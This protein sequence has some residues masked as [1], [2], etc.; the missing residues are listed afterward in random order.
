MGIYKE[1]LTKI[2]ANW[3]K[4]F[5]EQYKI[6][7]NTVERENQTAHASPTVEFGSYFCH[8]ISEISAFQIAAKCCKM[9]M[10]TSYWHLS[11]RLRSQLHSTVNS[12]NIGCFFPQIF[13]SLKHLKALTYKKSKQYCL[14]RLFFPSCGNHNDELFYRY[15]I[16]LFVSPIIESQCIWFVVQYIA[17]PFLAYLQFTTNCE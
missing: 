6:L 4:P 16:C 11:E 13:D 10:K 5:T 15:Q 14:F 3:R 8:Q 7:Q 12:F 9:T 2:A 1:K 17:L